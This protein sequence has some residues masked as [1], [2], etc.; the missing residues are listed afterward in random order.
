MS[1]AV[2]D[3]EQGDPFLASLGD[4]FQ[5]SRHRLRGGFLY[6]LFPHRLI[7]SGA[8]CNQPRLEGAVVQHCF[9]EIQDHGGRQVLK[10][11]GLFDT[12]C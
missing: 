10:V 12:G 11:S 5:D 2:R 4:K 8:L 3:E 7:E 6:P 1:P 9:V